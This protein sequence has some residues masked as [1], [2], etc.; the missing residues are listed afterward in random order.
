MHIHSYD[1]ILKHIN[2]SMNSISISL[3]TKKT[4]SA[5]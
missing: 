4:G 5:R 2:N 3:Q 1:F